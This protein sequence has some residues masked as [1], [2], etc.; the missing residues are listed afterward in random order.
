M[1]RIDP[2]SDR[3]P[4]PTVLVA[5][6]RG[7]DLDVWLGARHA[8]VRLVFDGTVCTHSVAAVARP[9]IDAVIAAGPAAVS[10]D[11][12]R[13]GFIDGRGITLL[14]ELRKATVDAGG[15]FSVDGRSPAVSGLVELCGLAPSLCP[16]TD[17]GPPEPARRL[18]MS[19]TS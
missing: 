16:D 13:V 19:P 8:D 6:T 11:V 14:V 18:Q 9:V 2:Q 10:V 17:G 15:A 1:S 3:R 7:P 5:S 4:H 12:S